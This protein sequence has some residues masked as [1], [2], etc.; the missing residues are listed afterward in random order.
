[1]AAVASKK[2]PEIL[3]ILDHLK[4]T[5]ETR[6][7]RFG[8]LM[9]N[10]GAPLRVFDKEMMLKIFKR[11]LDHPNELRHLTMT[12]I[13]S[14]TRAISL[15]YDPSME[16]MIKDIG[17]HVLDELKNRLDQIASR[18]FFSSF[19]IIIRNL[20]QI[21]VYDLELMENI[22]RPDFIKCIYKRSQQLCLPIYEI[23]G[24]N[25]INLRNIYKG[26]YLADCYTDK[27]R[28][29]SEYVPNR[30]NRHKKSE[31]FNYVLEDVISRLFTHYQYA[32]AVPHRRHAG[33]LLKSNH[34]AI[35][36]NLSTY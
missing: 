28:F 31:L 9:T 32:H 23:D 14:L 35:T 16:N 20:I 17:Y 19:I 29:L 8:V 6:P 15:F 11:C 34:L 21:H 12:D 4:A 5:M 3:K 7:L 27:L 13:E 18:T 24:Y 22:F 26:N 1:M 33:I 2:I 30:I 25:R 10:I 36:S